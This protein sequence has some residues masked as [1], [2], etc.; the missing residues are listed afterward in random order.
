LLRCPFE[1]FETIGIFVIFD[2]LTPEH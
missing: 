2:A 1:I